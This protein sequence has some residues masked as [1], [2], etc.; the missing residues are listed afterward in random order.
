MGLI[1]AILKVLYT[2]A[3]TDLYLFTTFS[4]VCVF[5][6]VCV[7]CMCVFSQ[8]QLDQ[9]LLFLNYEMLIRFFVYYNLRLQAEI[10]RLPFPF[11]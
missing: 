9:L 6:V 3:F 5:S 2:H 4:C 11:L 7:L 10:G 1:P 8:P